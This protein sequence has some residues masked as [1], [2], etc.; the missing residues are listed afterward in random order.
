VGFSALT[1]WRPAWRRVSAARRRHN[2]GSWLSLA[3]AASVRTLA[4]VEILF[5]QV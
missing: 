2:A 3:S 4:L 1:L 5:A